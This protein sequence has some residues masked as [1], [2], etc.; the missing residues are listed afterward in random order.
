MAFSGIQNNRKSEHTGSHD[1]GDIVKQT[2]I[3]KSRTSPKRSDSLSERSGD[4][5][6]AT[7]Y[8]RLSSFSFDLLPN[9]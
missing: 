6:D 1:S 9:V 2:N 8:K 3:R 5:T 7:N 4:T